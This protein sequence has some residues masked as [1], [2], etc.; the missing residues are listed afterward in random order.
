MSTEFKIVM[1]GSGGVGKSAITMQFVRGSF[2]E[3]YDP[4]VEDL[5]IKQITH[6]NKTY[7]L[8]ILDTAGFE[9]FA[10]MTDLYIR[11]GHGFILVYSI[12]NAQSYTEIDLIVQKIA[13]IK[14]SNKVPMIVVGNKLDL[15]Y[16]R[17]VD[18]S[19]APQ[20]YTNSSTSVVELT[21]KSNS[22]VHL[23]FGELIRLMKSAPK[24]AMR[25][26]PSGSKCSDCNIA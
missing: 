19:S 14:Q 1:L 26:K 4:T 22:Q 9:Q 16:N 5:Y 20:K 18:R 17:K 12:T 13:Q 21:A 3:N 6:E 23:M 7:V 2:I 11:N 15:N 25:P 8:E 24:S 10:T